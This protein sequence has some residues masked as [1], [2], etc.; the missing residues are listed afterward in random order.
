MTCVHLLAAQTH[1][2]YRSQPCPSKQR[3]QGTPGV[4]CTRSLACKTKKH[5]SIVTTGSPVST[6]VP[7]ANGFN[8]LFRALP[9]EP[10]FLATVIPKKLASQ[11]LDASVGASGPHGFAVR[12]RRA[13]LA[14]LASTASRTN[15]RDD[16]ETPLYRN[17]MARVVSVI[18]V[19]RETIYF[20]RTDWTG[21]ITL[22]WRGKSGGMR[23]G[24][25]APSDETQRSS[26]Y[27]S[28]FKKDFKVSP[29]DRASP[30]A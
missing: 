25:L 5:T 30:S 26:D 1:P 2:S 3:A 7:R 19:R 14:L 9:G 23:M 18:W 4:R 17:G 21:S 13:R 8:G 20:F 29:A 22:K 6:G 11:E 16:R 15:V 28:S 24:P 27:R 12:K 10:G